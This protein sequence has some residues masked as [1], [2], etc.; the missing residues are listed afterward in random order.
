VWD[1]IAIPSTDDYCSPHV[2]AYWKQ[3]LRLEPAYVWHMLMQSQQDGFW[4]DFLYMSKN[5]N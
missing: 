5:I 3:E 1:V 4:L 2:D